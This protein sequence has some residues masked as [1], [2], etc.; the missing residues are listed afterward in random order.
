M[1][2]CSW[3][4]ASRFVGKLR[5]KMLVKF[6]LR[7]VMMQVKVFLVGMIMLYQKIYLLVH[8]L[9]LVHLEYMSVLTKMVV[10]RW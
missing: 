1:D 7:M 5:G 6:D 4:L 3:Y 9:N 8:S 2:D 10:V